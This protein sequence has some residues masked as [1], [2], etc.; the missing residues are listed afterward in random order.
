MSTPGKQWRATLKLLHATGA[1]AHTH[2]HTHT[3][4]HTHKCLVSK[5]KETSY[6]VVFYTYTKINN[7][8]SSLFSIKL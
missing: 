6:S 1:R 5:S 8:G 3:Y 7:P 2:T 4:T